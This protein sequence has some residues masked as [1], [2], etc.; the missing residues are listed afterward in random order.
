MK[1]F[2][3]I[4]LV[5]LMVVVAVIG[6]LAAVTVPAYQTHVAVSEASRCMQYIAPTRMTADSLI[7]LNNGVVS[8]AG[9]T[10][11]ALD[12]QT[13]NG[14]VGGAGCD[15]GVSSLV[16]GN[17]FTIRGVTNTSLGMITMNMNRDGDGDWTWSCSGDADARPE[18]CP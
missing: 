11:V 9:V 10:T 18:L 6:I 2:A 4:T 17:T 8:G 14:V 12:I 5:E 1:N 13:T 7:Q 3:G 15:G 16:T